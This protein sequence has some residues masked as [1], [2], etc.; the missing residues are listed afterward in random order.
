MKHGK[1]L[2]VLVTRTIKQVTPS[3]VTY[4]TLRYTAIYEKRSDNGKILSSF[5]PQTFKHYTLC[6]LNEFHKIF[7]HFHRTYF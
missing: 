6:N 3:A 7:S 1:C 5:S 4:V 2:T